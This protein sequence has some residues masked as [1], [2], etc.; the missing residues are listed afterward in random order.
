VVATTECVV[1]TEHAV[2]AQRVSVAEGEVVAIGYDDIVL[3][4]EEL[5]A[6]LRLPTRDEG[7]VGQS[8]VQG[9]GSTGRRLWHCVEIADIRQ[10]LID[11]RVEHLLYLTPYLATRRTFKHLGHLLGCVM[12]VVCIDACV[13]C[14]KAPSPRMVTA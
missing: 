3:R 6:V 14:M 9:L 11:G 8:S 5:D 4:V 12:A 10:V 13:A 1:N 7:V 2:L